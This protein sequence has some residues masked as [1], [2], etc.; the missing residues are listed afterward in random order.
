MELPNIRGAE[1]SVDVETT[2]LKW[3][4]DEIFGVSLSV[5]DE[6]YYWDIRKHPKVLDWLTNELPKA[7][8][9]V[10]HNIKFDKHMLENENIILDPKNI[11]C[12]MMQGALIDEHLHDYSLDGMAKKYLG[13]GKLTEI[14]GELAAL[15]GGKATKLVQMPNLHRAPES[16]VAPY[17][18]MDTRRALELYRWQEKE[19]EKQNLHEVLALERR[20]FPHVYSMERKGICVDVDKAE[21]QLIMVDAKV[22]IFRKEL[23]KMAGFAVNPNP[24]GSIH[25]LFAPKKNP[26]GDWVSSCGVVLV[27][28]DAG[29]A[30]LDADALKRLKNPAARI[31]LTCRKLMKMRDTF[32]SGHILGNAHNGRVHPNI[33]QTKAE[34]GK[35]GVMGTTTGRLSYNEPA[36]QQIPARDKDMAAIAR[37]IFQPDPGQSWSYGDL[38]QHEFR[39]FAHYVNNPGIVQD[40][41]DNPNLDFHQRVADLT[42]LPRNAPEAGGANAKTVN[43]GMVMTMGAGHLADLVGLP[44]TWDEFKDEKGKTIR[45]QKAGE[46]AQ[47]MVE[48]Y[49]RAVPGVRT[50]GKKI[51]AVAKSRHYLTTLKGRRIRFPG[52]FAARKGPGMLYQGSSGD[53]NKENICRIGE[54]LESECPENRLLLNIHDEYS[55]SIVDDGRAEGHLKECRRLIEDRPEIRIPIRID[56]SKPSSNWWEATNAGKCT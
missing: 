2:G 37:P 50:L 9:I 43:L 5:R 13:E 18:K 56:F 42:G 11:Y 21:Q 54:Y 48:D 10:N 39:I 34:H 41:R 49:H 8:K 3:Y 4:Q 12:T 19:L 20:V 14:Y 7:K 6:D 29:N 35:G 44:W 16:V 1:I 27:S 45:Y 30:S 38:D 40:Y 32:I 25:K 26:S 24:S 33:N 53:L 46:E 31:L 47:E 28:T 55:I 15:F 36:L 17:A 22:K 23:D 51:K 52:G